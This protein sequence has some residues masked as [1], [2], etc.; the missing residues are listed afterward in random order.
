MVGASLACQPAPVAVPP[1]GW[2][3]RHGEWKV[4]SGV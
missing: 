3:G 2:I 1:I 4:E